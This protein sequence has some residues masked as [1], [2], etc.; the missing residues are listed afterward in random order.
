[1]SDKGVVFSSQLS[2]SSRFKNANAIESQ[3]MSKVDVCCEPDIN[4]EPGGVSVST[5]DVESAPLNRPDASNFRQTQSTSEGD[6]KDVY[7]TNGGLEKADIAKAV[8]DTAKLLTGIDD[9]LPMD[10]GFLEL[11]INSIG[12]I[13]F[14]SILSKKLGVYFSDED[15]KVLLNYSLQEIADYIIERAPE[16]HFP[17]QVTQIA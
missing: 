9:E 2:E 1:M 4:I 13:E 6:S 10:A 7:L 11:G 5:R 15:M 12:A 14:R 17:P 3:N 8:E 16:V